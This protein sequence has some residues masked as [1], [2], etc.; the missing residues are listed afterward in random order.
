MVP[1]LYLAPV[2]WSSIWQRPQHLAMRLNRHFAIH[3]VD[4]VGLRSVRLTDVARIRRS[5]RS[6]RQQVPLPSIKPR[7]LPWQGNRL[8]ECWNR[9]WLM[10][11]IAAQFDLRRQPWVLWIGSPSLLADELLEHTRPALVVYDAM[12]RFAAFHRGRTRR[13]IE[14]AEAKIMARA[15]VVFASSH[16]LAERCG[17]LNEVTLVPNGVDVAAFGCKLT[18]DPPAWHRGTSRR[19]IGFHGTLGDWLDYDLLS[20]LAQRHRDWLWV[21]LGPV[22]SRCAK[23]LLRLP[24]VCSTGAVAYT[25]LP[26]QA[27]WFDVGLVPFRLNELTRYVHPIKALEYLALGLPVVSARLPDLSE[28]AEVISFATTIDQWSARIESALSPAARHTLRVSARRRVAQAHDW[29][30]R[31]ATVAAHIA[32]RLQP[33]G[34]AFQPDLACDRLAGAFEPLDVRLESLT[35]EGQPC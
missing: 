29:D 9:R 30:S 25:A 14:Q 26:K 15:D 19:V 16:G 5:L 22:H 6:P 8:V 10:R 24:N 12:D 21:F 32:E 31:A 2:E 34:Q 23:P 33:V 28:H 11:Q 7:Y 27:A 17:A 3:Y 18:G 35:Y 1:I 4:P 13:R 20:H